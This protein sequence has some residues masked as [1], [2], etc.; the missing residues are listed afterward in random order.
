MR[1]VLG[2]KAG[3]PSK[4]NNRMGKME[5]PTPD[6][7]TGLGEVPHS[8]LWQLVALEFALAVLSDA[9]GRAT[10]LVDS[11]PG[12]L[13]SNYTSIKVFGGV[14]GQYSRATFTG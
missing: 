5:L 1:L 13:F 6:D 9:L 7:S 12:V 14:E 4:Y 3:V 10:T 11:L 8:R 2:V